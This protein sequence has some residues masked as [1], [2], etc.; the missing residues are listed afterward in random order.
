MTQ[1]RWSSIILNSLSGMVITGDNFLVERNL[2]MHN[3]WPGSYEGRSEVKN[4][5]Y[6]GSFDIRDAGPITFR[7]NV[8]S[9]TVS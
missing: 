6:E 4:V 2:I 9:I 7:D 8:V 3:L 5:F 1:H